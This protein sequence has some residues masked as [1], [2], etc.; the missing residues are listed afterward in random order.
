MPSNS[1][2]AQNKPVGS[3]RVYQA[4]AQEKTFFLVFLSLTFILWSLY[5]ALFN[6]PVVFDETLGKA[7]FFALPVLIFVNVTGNKDV[8]KTLEPAKLPF[9]LLRGLAYGGILGFLT[10]LFIALKQKTVFLSAP[11]FIADKFWFESFLALMTAFWESL[12]FFGFV[13]TALY[14]VL[15]KPGIGKILLLNSLIFL[16]FHLPNLFLRFAGLDLSFIVG[17]LYLFGF[18]QALIFSQEKSIYPLIMTHTIWGLIL[19]IHF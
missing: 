13:Q 19:M 4:R 2:Q 6:F 14:S 10:V 3:K 17:L 8:V 11:I 18:G 7:A 5:R 15:K 9:G 1:K 16:I 12:F